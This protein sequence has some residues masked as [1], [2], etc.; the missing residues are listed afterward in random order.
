[1][2]WF[3]GVGGASSKADYALRKLRELMEMRVR[4]ELSAR[5]YEVGND[6]KAR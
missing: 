5:G 4:Q 6:T 1:M 2:R 3:G